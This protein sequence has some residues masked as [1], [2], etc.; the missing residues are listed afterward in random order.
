MVKHTVTCTGDASNLVAVDVLIYL[1]VSN[2]K[3]K[4]KS[5]KNIILLCFFRDGF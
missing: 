2:T 5:T 4:P 1:K 3:L